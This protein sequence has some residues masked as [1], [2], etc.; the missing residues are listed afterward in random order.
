MENTAT[1]E[2]RERKLAATFVELADTLVDDYDLNEFLQRLT[3]RCAELVG[4]SAVGVLLTDLRGS[5]QLAAASTQDMHALEL[6][7]MQQQEG[8]CYEAFQSGEQVVEEDIRGAEARW[9]RFTP[10]AMDRGYRSVHAFPLRVRDQTLGALNVFFD[11]SGPFTGANILALQALADIAAIGILQQRNVQESSDLAGHLQLAL[12]SR[13]VIERAVGVLVERRGMGT[14]EAF[15]SLRSHARNT[16][17]RL[18][19]V[20]QALVDGAVPA[21]AVPADAVPGQAKG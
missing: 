5:L 9:P 16:N 18:R 8:P 15:E 10:Q 14:Q 11:H 6:F 7:E 4:A 3:S 2:G 21:D 19:V 17:Q 13:V 12:D 20:A 1:G